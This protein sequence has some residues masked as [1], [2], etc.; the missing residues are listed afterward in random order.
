MVNPLP[1]PSA[2]N[3]L[4]L[5]MEENSLIKQI[6]DVDGEDAVACQQTIKA[7]QREYN[8]DNSH[9]KIAKQL[10]PSKLI[11]F[12][13]YAYKIKVS[14]ISYYI[15]TTQLLLSTVGDAENRV[16]EVW[17]KRWGDRCMPHVSDG[18]NGHGYSE[19]QSPR[20]QHAMCANGTRSWFGRGYCG[21]FDSWRSGGC[22]HQAL[23]RGSKGIILMPPLINY[24]YPGSD[25]KDCGLFWRAS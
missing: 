12:L 22:G 1:L 25:G 5:A 20:R 3:W 9:I 10:S 8:L 19:R 16:E 4:R 13:H 23:P 6:M 11:D 21:W 24:M 2:D 7:L 15:Y 18:T 17:H 14:H